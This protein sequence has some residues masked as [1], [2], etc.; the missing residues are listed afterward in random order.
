MRH[1]VPLVSTS[2][3]AAFP[4]ARSTLA[5]GSAGIT[6]WGI[7]LTCDPIPAN[8]SRITATST[9]VRRSALDPARFLD[10][11]SKI[12]FASTMHRAEAASPS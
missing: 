6:P 3:S 10:T 8:A 1:S 2:C 12:L 4:L 9:A 7:H 5:W 11:V